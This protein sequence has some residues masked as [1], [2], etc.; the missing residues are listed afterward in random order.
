M[1]SENKG[2]DQLPVTM[3]PIC[4]FV[5]AYVKSRFAHDEA[6]VMLETDVM[7]IPSASIYR[8]TPVL[9][10]INLGIPLVGSHYVNVSVLIKFSQQTSVFT[11]IIISS[12]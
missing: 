11:L 1:C 4:A 6:R 10:I 7:R 8:Q 9:H 3:Q 5:F 2:T 12:P